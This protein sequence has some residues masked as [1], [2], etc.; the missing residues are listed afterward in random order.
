MKKTSAPKRS[1]TVQ[2]KGWIE[3]NFF[4]LIVSIIKIENFFA[5]DFYDVYHYFDL[6]RL[7]L[8]LK[9]NKNKIYTNKFYRN[10]IVRI[11]KK[12]AR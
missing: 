11:V 12:R 4:F 7:S 10:K 8:G 5:N 6:L 1:A 9:F 2:K 3:F